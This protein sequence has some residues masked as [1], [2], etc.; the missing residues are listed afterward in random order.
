MLQHGDEPL[1][2][3]L[4]AE[5]ERDV[6]ETAALRVS[7]GGGHQLVRR[8]VEVSDKERCVHEHGSSHETSRHTGR[9]SSEPNGRASA[10]KGLRR[11]VPGRCVKARVFDGV[12]P[13]RP[14][15]RPPRGPRP[16]KTQ[17]STAQ[18]V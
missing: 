16:Q 1:R 14:Q 9:R 13:V 11:T 8:A 5:K 3:G 18:H 12:R 17:E 4:M 7:Q 15:R 2:L 6:R 10:K